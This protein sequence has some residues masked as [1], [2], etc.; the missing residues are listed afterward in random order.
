[1]PQDEH[2]AY[3]AFKD[4]LRAA[5]TAMCEG[6]ASL[7]LFELPPDVF[8]RSPPPI[9]RIMEDQLGARQGVE[10]DVLRVRSFVTLEAWN[11]W[12]DPTKRRRAIEAINDIEDARDYL[13]YLHGRNK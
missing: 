1:M 8:V 10:W 4:R 13:G 5:L 7:E 9:G 6:W 3:Y 12:S 11:L 2:D